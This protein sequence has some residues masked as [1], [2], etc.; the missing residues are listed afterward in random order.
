MS[1]LLTRPLPPIS[2]YTLKKGAKEEIEEEV[3]REA[4]EHLPYVSI[5]ILKIINLHAS[6]TLSL[7]EPSRTG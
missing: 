7:L 5:Q 3:Y 2:S 1:I 6:Q 4:E